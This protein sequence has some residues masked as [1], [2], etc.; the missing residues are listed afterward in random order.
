MKVFYIFTILFLFSSIFININAQNFNNVKVIVYVKFYEYFGCIPCDPVSRLFPDYFTK[1][2]I[3]LH[4]V[5]ITNIQ[6]KYIDVDTKAYNELKEI[7]QKLN[8]P[9]FIYMQG[10][11]VINIDDKFLFINM[12]PIDFILDF[13][14]NYTKDYEKIVVF[15]DE[16]RGL[17][18][19]IDE[20]GLIKECETWKPIR[21]CF[22]ERNLASLPLSSYFSPL[23][24]IILSGLLD[25]INPCAFAVLLF[26]ITFIFLTISTYDSLE[27]ARKRVILIGFIYI[28]GIYI[29]YLA[30][31]LGLFGFFKALSYSYVIEKI[32]ALTL[33]LLGFIN[34]KDF[35]WQGKFFSLKI[36]MFG[37]NIIKKYL[38][39]STIPFVFI[40]GL[41]VSLFEFPCTGQ[42]Y[43][44]ILGLLAYRATFIQG[45]L[46]LLI[47]NIA[48]IFPLIFILFISTYRKIMEFSIKKWEK[49]LGKK[50]RL[51]SGLVMI[52]LGAFILFF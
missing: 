11:V 29:A 30:I 31:G 14:V 3:S 47:Y 20:N 39:K 17:Y 24:L 42:I 41:L 2:N 48:F 18:V 22:K 49:T 28:I 21:E 12:I 43:V 35:I 26:F 8:V 40:T 19:I 10:R 46:Y 27:K 6:L 7:Y 32:S 51:F 52:I 4:E 16:I 44:A 33:I 37:W 15:K 5:G 1:L 25:G 38:H 9:E 13:L 23:T 34:L 36:P 50:M 45:F